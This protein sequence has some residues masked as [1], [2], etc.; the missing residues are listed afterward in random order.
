MVKHDSKFMNNAQITSDIS[1]SGQTKGTGTRSELFGFIRWGDSGRASY[2]G[3]ALDYFKGNEMVH[4]SKQSAVY[5]ALQGKPESFLLD[6]QFHSVE[7]NFF[8]FKRAKTEVVGQRATKNNYRQVKRF[9]TDN[10]KTLELDKLPH[11]FTIRRQGQEATKIIASRD[12][13][14]HV[15]SS[16]TVTDA[17]SGNGEVNFPDSS[18]TQSAGLTSS[19]QKLDKRMQ[20]NQNKILELSRKIEALKK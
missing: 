17:V 3:E 7:K 8:F 1:I 18:V 10:T 12:I 4:A 16:I 13:P 20:E 14:D 6:P 5:N 9:N 2:E 11:T 15:T 19:I